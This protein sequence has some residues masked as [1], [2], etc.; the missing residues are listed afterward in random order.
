M[1]SLRS[2]ITVTQCTLA[3]DPFPPCTTRPWILCL[4]RRFSC[5][6]RSQ[7]ANRRSEGREDRGD[8][9]PTRGGQLVAVRPGDFGDE[10]VRAQEAQLPGDPGRAAAG[11]FGRLEGAGEEDRLQIPVAEAIEGELAA[12]HRFEQRAVVAEGPER[13]HPAAL[14]LFRLAEAPDEFVQRQVVVHAGEGV[15]VALGGPP[16]D[17]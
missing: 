8:S 14:P 6:E 13:P 16:R 10:A 4:P 17:L 9:L 2:N 15:Q 12:A 1:L 3:P 5:C 11:F 7:L